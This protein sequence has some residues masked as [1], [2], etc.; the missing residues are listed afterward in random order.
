MFCPWVKRKK[1]LTKGP[2]MSF[3]SKNLP[4][5]KD[6]VFRKELMLAETL[7]MKE[8][9]VLRKE[10]RLAEIRPAGER[11]PASGSDRIETNLKEIDDLFLVDLARVGLVPESDTTK[12]HGAIL[13]PLIG[14]AI[15]IGIESR[16]EITGTSHPTVGKIWIAGETILLGRP[17]IWTGDVIGM[18][19]QWMGG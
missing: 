4:L 7:P 2:R 14:A 12:S 9:R 1:A 18:L 6:Q 19:P 15:K 10:K 16:R 13:L 5:K 8:G 17:G 11:G 3:L